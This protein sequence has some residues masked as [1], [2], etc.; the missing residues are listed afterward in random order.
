MSRKERFIGPAAHLAESG[1]KYD[2]LLGGIEMA[3]RF[4]N[5]EGDEE[6][7]ELAK[8]L[9]SLDAKAAVKDITG[10]EEEHPLFN[11]VVKVVE[12]VKAGSS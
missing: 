10:L 5:V 1:D 2:F 8:K 3:F 4:Q 9:Q 12:K 7:A 11:D 6:S